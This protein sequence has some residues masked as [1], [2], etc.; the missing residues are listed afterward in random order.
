[1]RAARQLLDQAAGDEALDGLA[2]RHRAQPEARRQIVDHERG[3]GREH[4]RDDRVA[5]ADEGLD[6]EIAG[7]DR[8]QGQVEIVLAIV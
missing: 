3:A 1:V 7:V 5:D 2:H 8:S 6:A 4:A